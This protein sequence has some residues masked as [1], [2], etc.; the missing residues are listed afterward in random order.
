MEV[1]FDQAKRDA[2]LKH[3]GLDFA[4][5]ARV[6]AGLTATVQ[7]DRKAYGED[8]FITAGTLDGRLVVLVWTPREGGSCPGTWCNCGVVITAIS[9]GAGSVRLLLWAG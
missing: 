2:T 1:T 6:F 3:R 4:D 8:R 9:G 5:A 7:D